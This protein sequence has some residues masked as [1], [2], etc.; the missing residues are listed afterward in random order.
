MIIFFNLAHI[1]SGIIK[2]IKENWLFGLIL[3]AGVFMRFIPI[4]QYQFSHDEL[5]GLS[6]TVFPNLSQV[7]EY[8]VKV[9]DTHPALIQIFLWY[10]VKFFGLNEIAIK[11]P[12]LMCG[13]LSIWFVFK[14][15]KRFFDEKSA[16]ISATFLSLSF[17][18][19][20]F[21]SYARMYI[22]GVLFSIL[23]LNSVFRILFLKETSIWNFVSYS[24]LT[25]LCAYNHHMSCLFAASV[26]FLSLFYLPKEKMVKF[27]AF[28][29]LSILLYLPHLSITLYQF[30][31]GGIGASVGGW[32][33]A[34]RVN[35]IYFFLKA[36]MGC[37]FAGK[38]NM[39]LCFI[40][41]LISVFKLIPITKKQIFLLWIF[42][43]NYLVI[44]LYSV[45]IN[46][47]LQYSVLLFAGVGFIVFLSTFASWLSQKQTYGFIVLL[48]I[49][50]SFQSFKKKHIFSKV[51]V[52]D[53][54]M[55]VRATLNTQKLFGNDNVISV[56]GSERYFVSVYEKKFNT[57]LKYVC[58]EDSI[59]QNVSTF[60][61]FLGKSKQDYLVL[62]GL[63]PMKI[64][65]AKEYFPYLLSHEEDYFSNVTVL[66]KKKTRNVDVSILSTTSVFNSDMELYVDKAK[67]VVFYGD[68][69]LYQVTQ[70]TKEFPFAVKIPIKKAPLQTN[71]FLVAELIYNIDSLGYMG[72]DQL[73]MSITGKQGENIYYAGTK[74]KDNLR[75]DKA[76]QHC[77][78]EFHAG[79]EF[80]KMQRQDLNMECFLWKKKGS[81]FNI[82]NFK[83]HVLDYNPTKWTLWD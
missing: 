70:K 39:I 44:H 36:L 17:I 72:E 15:C 73:C 3:V 31:T 12:F 40:I 78:V 21:S 16:L 11:L 20:V 83:L 82:S 65:M 37:G 34:P 33:S 80:G 25:L 75:S 32:L 4:N 26:G 23:L 66:S 42:V 9:M 56:F 59:Y 74:L 19:L 13:I 18:F 48:M 30:S 54:E 77:Y 22:P 79:T 47:I 71:Q 7:L 51:H 10:W 69:I 60:R 49:G 58:M 24:L 52:H 27:I 28:S 8:G 29:L 5:S 46:P 2:N 43:I 61:H 41:V 67:P 62:A 64:L 81:V 6:R 63:S 55:Q 76:Q 45:Y 50:F 68:S 1:L 53:F 57:K 38:L 14:F 35:E